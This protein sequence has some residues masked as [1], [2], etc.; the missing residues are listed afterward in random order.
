M[1]AA[2]IKN[3]AVVNFALVSDFDGVE[4]VNPT[5]AVI[6]STWGGS[7]FTAPVIPKVVP[8]YV[9]MKQARLTLLG[10]GMLSAVSTAVA[11]FEGVEGEAA[12]I[13]WEYS[14]EVRRYDALTIA[15]GAAI[16]LSSDQID[17]LFI[18]AA[19]LPT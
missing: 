15:L 17:D 6:G 9:T 1:R 18:T 10:A 5:G 3:G 14:T 19:Q 2:Q 16:G 4:F 7:K 13:S 8:E 12:R 11:G